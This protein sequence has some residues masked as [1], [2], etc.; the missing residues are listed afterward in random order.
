MIRIPAITSQN[1]IVSSGAPADYPPI[2]QEIIADIIAGCKPG[3]TLEEEQALRL[4]DAIGISRKRTLIATN[5][6]EAKEAVT[7]IGLPVCMDSISMRADGSSETVD[8]VTDRN[9]MRLEFHRMMRNS[10]VKGVRFSPVIDGSGAYFGIRRRARQGHIVICGTY[11]PGQEKPD[12]FVACTLPVTKAEAT[13]MYDRV[14]AGRLTNQIL[15]VDTLR[16]LSALCD[17]APMIDKMDIH[18]T[19]TTSRGVIALGASVKII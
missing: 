4:L 7:D 8:R 9:T 15:F 1:L 2:A 13:E 6:D 18:P 12:T 14:K 5:L 3:A 10:D 11:P 16:R 17:F 19:V